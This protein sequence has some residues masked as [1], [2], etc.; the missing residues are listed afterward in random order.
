MVDFIEERLAL[1]FLSVD[2]DVFERAIVVEGYGSVVEEVVVA[3]EIHAAVG[4][5]ATHVL[6]QLLAVDKRSVQPVDEFFLLGSQRIGVGRVDRGENLVTQGIFFP[7]ENQHATRIVDFVEQQAVVHFKIGVR[8][9]EL[10]FEFEL[11]DGDGFVHLRQEAAGLVAI[12]AVEALG[13]EE[14]AGVVFVL[15]DGK[16][17]QRH[18]VDAVTVFERAVVAIPHRHANDI[19][20]AA[21]V[22]GGRAHPQNIVVA[23]LYIDVVIGAEL[24][25]DDFG[26]GTAVEDV[27]HDMQGVDDQP[28]YEVADG[29]DAGIGPAGGDDGGDDAVDISLLVG[30]YLRLVQQLLQDVREF[31]RQGFAHFGAGVLRGDVLAHAYELVHRDAVPVGHVFFLLLD[32]FKFLLGIVNQGTKFLDF[33]L[34]QGLAEDFFDFATHRTRCV[35]EHMEECFIFTVEVGEKM[36]RTFGQ[37]ENGFK[38]DNLGASIGDGRELC[39]QQLQIPQVIECRLGGDR[40]PFFHSIDV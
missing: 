18:E 8:K 39:R 10:S 37:V 29:T 6:A 32:E 2:G 1:V 40:R 28:L 26:A 21:V 12:F 14:G 3:H 19:G 25:H 9:N 11:Y 27:A 35:F 17:G 36:F 20:H 30:V 38:V 7:V 22:A 34:T 15:L 16:G 4:E 33:A 24:V 13:Q 5:E 31:G 23:P